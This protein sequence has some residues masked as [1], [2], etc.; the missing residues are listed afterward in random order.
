MARKNFACVYCEKRN[1][2]QVLPT[3]FIPNFSVDRCVR[4]EQSV[5]LFVVKSG[6]NQNPRQKLMPFWRFIF[7]VN[8]SRPARY[9]TRFKNIQTGAMSVKMTRRTKEYNPHGSKLR[10]MRIHAVHIARIHTSGDQYLAMWLNRAFA[11]S[12]L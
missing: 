5:Q 12:L 3:T 2:N 4:K 6:C 11:V 8:F 7:R 9:L 1:T 10:M